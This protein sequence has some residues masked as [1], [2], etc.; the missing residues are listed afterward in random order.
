MR[1]QIATIE[2]LDPPGSVPA[3]G[4]ECRFAVRGESLA[5]V[6]YFLE[7]E[8]VFYPHPLRS[9]SDGSIRLYPEA[10]GRYALHA[11]WRSLRG[12]SGRTHTEFHVKGAHGS[13]PQLVTAEGETLW[14]PTAR[15]AE[16]LSAHERPVFRELQKIIRPGAT[17]YDVGANVGL[18][19]ARLARWAGAEGWLY[20]IEPNPLCVYFLRA[21]LE[22]ARVR[23]F[24]ILPVALSNRSC[25]CSFSINYGSSLIGVGGDSTVAGKPGH[26]IRVEGESLDTLIATFN[27]RKP[28]FIK[29]DVEGAEA[30]A[31]EGMMDTL[32]K[33]R[34]NFM[35]ELH[36]REAGSETLRRLA[37]LGYEYLL[38]STG[39]KYRTAGAL[40]DSLPEAC[41][42]V[43]GYA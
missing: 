21:N 20:A 28:D 1:I 31:V 2:Q 6:H 4:R 27:L 33:G 15:D 34:P 32:E 18:F 29:L 22:H 36:G 24:T 9:E 42:Q 14:V 41:V 11:A 38:S 5:A 26:R 10:P 12:E 39:V 37:G 35:I 13:A 25:E 30:S 3:L 23:N 8:G 7:H 16:I 43:I 19:S 40:L 17:V